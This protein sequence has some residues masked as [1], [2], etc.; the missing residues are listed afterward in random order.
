MPPFAGTVEEME[1]VSHYLVSLGS[2]QIL[3]GV[4]IDRG[5][6]IFETKCFFCHASEADWPMERLA[7]DKTADEF[8]EKI[9]RLPEVNPIMPPFGGTDE[10]RRLLAEYLAARVASTAAGEEEK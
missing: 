8:Y 6:R 3:K 4:S 9:A 1:L 2:R 10:E 5:Q 7:P